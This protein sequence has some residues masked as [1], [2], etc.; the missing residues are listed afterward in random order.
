MSNEP[1]KSEAK[2]PTNCKSQWQ[3][4]TLKRIGKLTDIVQGGGKTGASLDSDPQVQ[5]KSG[6]G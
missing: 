5:F 3:T 6:I 1:I 4:P 2:P